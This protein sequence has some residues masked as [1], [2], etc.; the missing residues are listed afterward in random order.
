MIIGGQS[1]YEEFLPRA[2]SLYITL[3]E[4][5]V[6]GDTF[7]PEYTHA[8]WEEVSREAHDADAKNPYP[9]TFVVLRRRES[10]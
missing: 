10:G 6:E 8:D 4:A 1:L 9:Y 7:F 3:I 5:R 2:D